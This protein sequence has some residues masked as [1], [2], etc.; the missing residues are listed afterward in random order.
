MDIDGYKAFLR[1]RQIDE[2]AIDGAVVSVQGFEEYMTAHGKDVASAS[3]HDFYSYS[4]HL[5]A[6][7]RNT[8]ENYTN[9]LRYGYFK[10]HKELMVCALEVLDGREVVKN[11]SDR[12]ITE[13][14]R[15]LRDSIFE[16]IVIPPLG[17]KPEEKPPYTSKLIARLE[18]RIGTEESAKFLNRGLRD[19]YEEWRRPEREKFLRAKSI[20]EFLRQKHEEL[21]AELEAHAKNGTLF[22]TQEVTQDVVDHVRNDAHIESGVREGERII[23]KK[24]PHMAKEYLIEKDE[25]KRRYYYCHCPWVK[26]SLRG[27]KR[28]VPAVFCNCSAGFYRAYWEIVFGEPVRV[29]VLESLLKGDPVCTFAVHIPERFVGP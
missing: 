27:S 19:R 29:E 16:G 18:E 13:Y 9:I 2:K 26:D 3:R 20:D 21:V 14:D 15:E 4:E 22:F 5:I 6:T 11:L 17:I 25:Q 28:S 10:K 23:V 24:I 1:A 7:G 8:P 12:L